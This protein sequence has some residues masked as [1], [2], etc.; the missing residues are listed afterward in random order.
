MPGF[1]V[2]IVGIESASFT[3]NVAENEKQFLKTT[4]LQ[5]KKKIYERKSVIGIEAMRL[6]FAGKQMEDVHPTS[7]KDMVLEDYNIQ[8]YST[9]AIVSRVH[10]GSSRVPVPENR[11]KTHDLSVL[12]LKF[13]TT[14]PDAI[15]GYSED[16]DQP[17]V[18]MTCGHYTDPNT[19][20]QYCRSLINDHGYE[21]VCPAILG[22]K[23]LKKCGKVWEYAEV[24]KKGI[25][26]DA[27]CQFYESKISE[28]AASTYC[29]IKECPGCKSY[30][31]RRDLTNLR[32]TCSICKFNGK[33]MADY[34]W[35]C[36][37]VWSGPQ[38]SS[39]KCG[40]PKCE[41]PDIPAIRDCP[42]ITL[43]EAGGIRVPN[44]RACP[45]CGKVSEHNGKACKNIICPKCKKQFCFACLKLTVDCQ[46]LKPSSWY[47]ACKDP[48]APKQ[49]TIPVWSR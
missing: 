10:G 9:I 22:G 14:E 45:T 12:N 23:S 16:G 36:S 34:C 49:T 41:H 5:L 35:Q 20:T 37:S 27:E 2:V 43:S 40:N 25:F 44:R 7:G 28:N 15:F 48:I 39:E 29:E 32:F 4:V 42:M 11:E 3:V 24:R 6:L 33:Q 13:S 19:L 26:S 8:N 21:F 18:K 46:K 38:K 1:G 30:I 47:Q 31:E 17:R